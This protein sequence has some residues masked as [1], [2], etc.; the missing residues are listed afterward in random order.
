MEKPRG[1]R[2]WTFFQRHSADKD[3]CDKFFEDIF[4]G[5]DRYTQ[6]LEVALLLLQDKTYQ[7]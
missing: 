6:R 3:E 4:V 5:A 1:R 7:K 2:I